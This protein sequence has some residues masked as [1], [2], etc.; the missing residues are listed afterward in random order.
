MLGATSE[1][2]DIQEILQKITTLYRQYHAE[3]VE[4]NRDISQITRNERSAERIVSQLRQDSR[5]DT[6]QQIEEER[7]NLQDYYVAFLSNVWIGSGRRG[8]IQRL[9][10]RPY[11]LEQ[12]S[13]RQNPFIVINGFSRTNPAH[14]SLRTQINNIR[15]PLE[16]FNTAYS[17]SLHKYLTRQTVDL[18]A[19]QDNTDNIRAQI[20]AHFNQAIS[21]QIPS[22]SLLNTAGN[23]PSPFNLHSIW[24]LTFPTGAHSAIMFLIAPHLGVIASE[25]YEDVVSY[26]HT[27]YSLV[28]NEITRIEIVSMSQ[29]TN[30]QALALNTEA[31]CRTSAQY[32]QLY[33]YTAWMSMGQGRN[34]EKRE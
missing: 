34:K 3:K 11:F 27:Y 2:M 22:V 15:P 33:L 13:V 23:Q 6:N 24:A 4:R 31:V 30:W 17:L 20:E 14:R 16:A 12:P 25:N 32:L 1:G 7:L 29:L 26:L 5:K 21:R 9:S 28:Q 19:S 8:S 18:P 10:P